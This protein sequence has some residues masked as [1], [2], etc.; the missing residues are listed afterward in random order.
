MKKMK[1]KKEKQEEKAMQR[2]KEKIYKNVEEEKNRRQIRL[3]EKNV[4]NW[5]KINIKL[6]YFHVVS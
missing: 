1:S 5:K 4:R 6:Y 3:K 2:R